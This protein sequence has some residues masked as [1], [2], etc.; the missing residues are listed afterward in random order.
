MKYEFSKNAEGNAIANFSGQDTL[1]GYW[2]MSNY[3]TPSKDL[4]RLLDFSNKLQQDLID[5]FQISQKGYYLQL[6]VDNAK[7]TAL[8]TLENPVTESVQPE[9]GKMDFDNMLE[10]THTLAAFNAMLEQWQ[11]FIAPSE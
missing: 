6:S 11:T 1:I 5:D 4:D 10:C 8:S 9:D 2:L 3:P 7:L